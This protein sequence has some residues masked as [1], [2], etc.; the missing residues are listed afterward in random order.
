MGHAAVRGEDGH[1]PRFYFALWEAAAHL[2]P[3]D[4]EFFIQANPAIACGRLSLEQEMNAAKSMPEAQ[5]RRYR[6]NQF[7]AAESAWL[8][9]GTWLDLEQ[10]EVPKGV[11]FVLTVDRSPNWTG[12]TITASAKVDGRVYTEVVASLVNP[13]MEV[14]ET[15][16]EDLYRRLKPMRVF[17]RA[18]VLM[19]LS[20][21]LRERGVQT[22]FLTTA[23]MQNVCAVAYAMI[24]EG[25]VAHA[26]D[27][28]VSTQ[29]PK[30][31]AKNVG[32]G[33]VIS[34]KDSAGDVDAVI[35]TLLG[36]Y[37]AE[38]TRAKSPALVIG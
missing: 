14:L 28:V 31:V 11:P 35:A 3:T 8:P 36:I 13:S 18:A 2:K 37:G 6:G 15:T 17:M 27:W 9:S 22:E 10:G 34:T 33:W 30:A 23:Q 4:P 29:M 24:A 12:A 16:I 19:D 1:D 26:H 32:D 25:R 5:V 21:R 20:R 7:V 38:V